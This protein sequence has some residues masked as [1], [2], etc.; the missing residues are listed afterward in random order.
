MCSVC[1]ICAF[2]MQFRTWILRF[3]QFV[4]LVCDFALVKILGHQQTISLVFSPKFPQI[5]KP[6]RHYFDGCFHFVRKSLRIV[7][8]RKIHTICAESTLDS[9]IPQNLTRSAQ[10]R[11]ISHEVRKSFCYFWLIP[12][13]ESLLILPTPINLSILC[14]LCG[15]CGFVESNAESTNSQNLSRRFYNSP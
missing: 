15:F 10:N 12:K 9:T 5:Q 8:Y 7:G 11:R 2:A 13:V 1:L 3:L 4:P 6:H 14:F